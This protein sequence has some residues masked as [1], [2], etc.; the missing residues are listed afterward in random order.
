[1]AIP[2]H[3]EI[4]YQNQDITRLNVLLQFSG[5]LDG[6]T[7]IA[8]P[9]NFGNSHKLHRSIRQFTSLN[10]E[11]SVIF[12]GDTLFVRIYHA[13]GETLNLSYDIV[14]DFE[15][16]ALNSTC[17]FRPIIEKN[18]FHV[19]G[20]SLFLLPNGCKDYDITL[21]WT[22]FPSNWKLHNSIGTQQTTQRFYT[23]TSKW[24]ESVFVGGDF[25]ILESKVFEKPIY[26]A[27]RGNNWNFGDQELLS[28]LQKTVETQRKFWNDVD[29]PYY[30]VT[31]LPI[32]N[33]LEG[34]PFSEQDIYYL[35][36]G[37]SNSFAA[38]ASPT[39]SLKINYLYHL[40]NHEMMHDWIG[41]KIRT[42][43]SGNDMKYAWFSEGFTE[44]FAYKNMFAA[45]FISADEYVNI[46]NKDFMS[47]YYNSPLATA[48]NSNIE[49]DF[50]N[51]QETCTL[52]YKRG[53]LLAFYLDNAIKYDSGN[54]HNLHDFMIQMLD[55]YYE[56]DFGL[57]ENFDFFTKNLDKYMKSRNIVQYIKEHVTDGKLLEP[58]AYVL[59]SFWKINIDAKGIPNLI[60]DK[61]VEGWE[62][63]LAR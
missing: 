14:Q 61:K 29:I 16:L 28:M 25:R 15:P 5:D 30:S 18:Y 50:F 38:F 13:P 43:V 31:L 19:L 4:K 7:E 47:A 59:P 27:I 52:P 39:K 11:N 34:I 23:K 1:M 10:K 45:G 3:Y 20:Y 56:N 51:N 57:N 22:S 62:N 63:E 58:D 9:D 32:P 12:D 54:R 35:G 48:P 26:L 24:L 44:Y 42:G 2:I 37:L 46:L 8:L 33:T 6:V 36:T 41:N 17:A 55:F 40:F 60:L 49:K 21:N 53:C